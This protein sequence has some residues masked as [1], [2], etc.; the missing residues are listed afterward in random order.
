MSD[1]KNLT[2]V[3]AGGIYDPAYTPTNLRIPVHT[4]QSYCSSHSVKCLARFPNNGK[5]FKKRWFR[6]N[7]PFYYIELPQKS[8]QN[9]PGIFCRGRSYY[10]SWGIVH[11]ELILCHLPN[12][13]YKLGIHEKHIY[14][15][16]CHIKQGRHHAMLAC[17]DRHSRADCT[18]KQQIP[19]QVSLQLL[20]VETLFDHRLLL[21]S[22]RNTF[23]LHICIIKYSN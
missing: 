12:Y 10:A 5:K 23:P 2:Y 14:P 16:W 8:K 19:P 11:P 18:R 4:P 21:H 1:S 13:F 6:S 15:I 9:E 20:L 3:S 22:A 17:P 7:L